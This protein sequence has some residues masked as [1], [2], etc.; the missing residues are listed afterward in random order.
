MRSTPLIEVFSPKPVVSK[1]LGGTP[2]GHK[3]LSSIVIDRG[4]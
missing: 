3:A 4:L 2:T 1:L